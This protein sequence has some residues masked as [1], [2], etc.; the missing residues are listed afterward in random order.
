[1]QAL[2]VTLLSFGVHTDTMVDVLS[3]PLSRLTLRRYFRSLTTAALEAHARK[4]GLSLRASYP[5]DVGCL[6][7]FKAGVFGASLRCGTAVVVGCFTALGS[8]LDTFHS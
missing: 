1:M 5:V 7:V 4:V 6:G 3:R 2:L 8:A